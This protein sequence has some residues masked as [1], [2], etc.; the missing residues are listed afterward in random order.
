MCPEAA[1]DWG[2]YTKFVTEKIFL[3]IHILLSK[4]FSWIAIPMGLRKTEDRVKRERALILARQGLSAKVISARTGLHNTTVRDI[5]R[6]NNV[7]LETD[8]LL[9]RDDLRECLI[10]PSP[11]GLNYGK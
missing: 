9:S 8:S 4:L 10:E 2:P 3:P 5:C 7:T 1:F 6:R 11:R